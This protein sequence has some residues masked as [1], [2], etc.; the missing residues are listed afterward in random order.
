[1]SFLQKLANGFVKSAVNQV[2]RD[3]GRV[4]S[5]KIYGDTHATRVQVV[6]SKEVFAPTALAELYQYDL[7]AK[8]GSVIH[9]SDESQLTEGWI[10][11]NF[12]P[13]VYESSF[14]ANV[15]AFIGGAFLPILGPMYWLI[16]SVSS[17]FRSKV[18]YTGIRIAPNLIIDKRFKEG[19]RQDG[20]RKE[21]IT[22]FLPIEKEERQF[23][24][25]GI[26][27]FMVGIGLSIFQ[28][29]AYQ[30]IKSG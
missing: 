25:K 18:V 28:W 13:Q 27:C 24:I 15:F 8:D 3:S 5:N 23:L 17:F 6:E 26:V 10:R 9:F 2:G 22:F 30:S 11:S 20:I 19:F 4:I 7:V 14:W 12:Q 1:M 29:I 16:K 21:E